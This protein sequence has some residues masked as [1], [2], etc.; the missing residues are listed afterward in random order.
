MLVTR[1]RTKLN[2]AIVIMVKQLEIEKTFPAEGRKDHRFVTFQ[3]RGKSYFLLRKGIQRETQ[4]HI[5]RIEVN[6]LLRG[7]TKPH[8]YRFKY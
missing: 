1:G 7:S 4:R 3:R 8:R 2:W 6:E 5:P